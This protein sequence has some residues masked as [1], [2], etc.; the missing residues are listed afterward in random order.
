METTKLLYE[1]EVLLDAQVK[2]EENGNNSQIN[3]K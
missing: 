1:K 2:V 3:Q